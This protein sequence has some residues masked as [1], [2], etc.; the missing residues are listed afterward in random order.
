MENVLK[1][2]NFLSLRCRNFI[3]HDSG[4]RKNKNLKNADEIN[5]G[6]LGNYG[7]IIFENF[8]ISD[9]KSLFVG[10]LTEF[11]IFGHTP[12]SKLAN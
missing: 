7:R 2:R 10:I 6:S 9:A 3:V 11:K 1:L 8:L 12:H 4:S 5:V